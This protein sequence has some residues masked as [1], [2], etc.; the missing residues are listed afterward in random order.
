MTAA[1]E[2]G[3]AQGFPLTRRKGLGVKK[4][5]HKYAPE[6]LRTKASTSFF[7]V[8]GGSDEGAIDGEAANK[9]QEHTI[10]EIV[11]GTDNALRVGVA[12]VG[13]VSLLRKG[14]QAR[15]LS[16]WEFDVGSSRGFCSQ[17]SRTV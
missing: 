15:L 12:D 14:H 16:K 10:P 4:S 1:S 11:H 3:S 2:T 17:Q 7:C 8:G 9:V 6:T 5:E 13:G